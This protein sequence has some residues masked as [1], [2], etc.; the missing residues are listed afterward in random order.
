MGRRMADTAA[1]LVEQVLPLVPVRQWVLSFPYELRYRLAWD[2]QLLSAVL[3][4][5]QR[6]VQGWYRRQAKAQGHPRGRCG[7]VTFVQRFGSSINLNPHLHVLMLDGVYVDG[8][9][10]D[11]GDGSDDGSDG[12]EESP[13]R[14]VPAPR[15]TDDDVQRIV[16]TTARRVVRLCQRRGLFDDGAVD[17]YWEQ[18]PLLAQL[19][20]ASVQGVV[21]TGERAGRRV[22]R[23]LSDPEDGVRTGTLCYA[24]RG[25]SLHAATR[26]EAADR[27]RLERLC[28]YVIRPPVAARRLRV[29]DDETLVFQLKTPWAD[30]TTS[31]VLSPTEL[32]E[33]LAAPD[34]SNGAAAAHQPH[35]LPR[36]P[37]AGRHRPRPHRA[38]T[39]DADGGGWR[40][41]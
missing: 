8:D 41:G 1:R 24:A 21:A 34:R 40:R 18:E 25:F 19:A 15:L 14:F 32:L 13:P 6:V 4:V 17:P 20:A 16:Q 23:Q 2:G 7:A 35:P 3:A 26:I 39:V 37:G 9:D 27:R 22:R 28:R 33:K 36:R 29:V 38:R 10:D 31:L 12:G 5:F 11:G 30:G